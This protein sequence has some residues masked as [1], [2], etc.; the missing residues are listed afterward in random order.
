MF[1]SA[2]RRLVLE[3]DLNVAADPFDAGVQRCDGFEGRRERQE[4]Q[5]GRHGHTGEE[6]GGEGEA[7]PCG[8]PREKY[9]ETRRPSFADGGAERSVFFQFTRR[10]GATT[11]GGPLWHRR[12]FLPP[13]EAD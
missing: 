1:P 10:H 2:V 9:P 13:S 7:G 11:G 6:K 3:E 5:Q 12:L 4:R 8:Q